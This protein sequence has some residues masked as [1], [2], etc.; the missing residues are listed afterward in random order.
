MLSRRYLRIKVFQA[1]YAYWQSDEASAARIEKELI[2]SIDRTYDLYLALLLVF[3]ELRHMAELRMEERRNKRLPTPED[4][5]PNRRFVDDPVMRLVAHNERLRVE[6]EARK[7]SWVGHHELFSKLFREVEA[8]PAYKTFM[9]DPDPSFKKSQTFFIQLFTEHVVN[10]E[11]VQDVFESRS[12]H[13]MEDLDLAAGLVKRLL[14]QLQ[15]GDRPAPDPGE[16][17]R[18]RKEEHEFVTALYRRSI[19]WSPE[20]E[21]AI[22]GKASNWES[23]RI[24][25]SDMVL[26]QMALTEARAFDQ[27]PV[28]VTLN[29]YIEIAKAY[30]TPNSKNFINGVL[31]KLFAEMRGDGRIHKVGRGLLET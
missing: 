17:I 4:L 19:E 23:D 18:D 16:F 10:N 6:C 25:L 13:W 2:T 15:P 30:S 24:N 21:A 11:A 14:E 20:H 27:I 9:A 7:V 29:E 12:I 1:L 26:M 22:A 31:D 8:S 5:S 28:K 3:G